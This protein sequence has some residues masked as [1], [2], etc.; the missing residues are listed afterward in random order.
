MESIELTVDHN[1]NVS[2]PCYRLTHNTECGALSLLMIVTMIVLIRQRING[3]HANSIGLNFVLS[4]VL[5]VHAGQSGA[6][7]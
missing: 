5:R 6:C 4:A 1:G 3:D 7:N 2:H